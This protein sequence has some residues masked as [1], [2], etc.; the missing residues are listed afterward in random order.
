MEKMKFFKVLLTLLLFTSVA[1]A[2]M[3]TKVYDGDTVTTASGEKIR[4]ACIDSP[5]MSNNRHGKK[6]PIGGPASKKWLSDLIL[7]TDVKIQRI[8][9]DLYGRTIARLFLSDGTEINQKAVSTKHA[10]IYMPK[11][12]EWANKK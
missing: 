9:K 6:D 3:I 7:N 4:L 5:E 12:C 10:V 8:T 11:S 1:K 2:D